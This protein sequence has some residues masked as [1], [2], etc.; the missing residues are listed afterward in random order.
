MKIAVIGAGKMGLPL[1]CQIAW[2]GGEVV[3][4]DI[5]PE[6]VA[7][8]NA[9]KMPFAEPGVGAILEQAVASGSLR[10]STEVG[11]M[12][13]RAE[14]V[15]V[16]IPVLLT[17][18]R[19]ADLAAIESVTRLIAKHLSAGQMICYETTLPVG[20]TRNRLRPILESSGLRAGEDFDL[21]F[22]PERVK[23]HLVLKHLAQVPKIVGGVN[24]SSARRAEAFYGA[25]LGAPV[26][27][28]QTLEA[29]EFSKLAG[30]I[31]RD[32]NIALANELAAYAESVGLDFHSVIEA[33]NTDSESALL[34][35]GIG[36]GGHC[37]PVY[38]YFALQDALNRG[39]QL[40]LTAEARRT[41]DRQA[42][43][44]LDR[45]EERGENLRGQKL[46]I[47]G[48]G[49]RPNVKEH[50]LSPAFLIRDEAIRR[51]AQPF[52]HDPLYSAEEI[53]S[54][55]FTPM[56]LDGDI[57]AVVVLNTGHAEYSQIALSGWWERGARIVVDGRNFWSAVEVQA[58]GLQYIAP[59]A[60]A[61]EEMVVEEES[62]TTCAE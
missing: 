26:I 28:V 3:A 1:A 58:A 42:R 35:P 20:T 50:T 24:Q 39:V 23:S 9:G 29:A 41:N 48:L 21:V 4:C 16:I 30:M 53:A 54:H 44:M 6:L 60:A 61:H 2:R 49:F 31:Y 17:A 57:P 15:I 51:G 37:T 62:Q 12:A 46:L 33:A 19:E 34:S 36:V 11:E 52:L 8:I 55:G 7:T 43:R 47:L 14:V 10:A 38:P 45:I 59:G 40:P 18:R 56:D 5:N 22:S 25:Y 27:N 32:V 13:G